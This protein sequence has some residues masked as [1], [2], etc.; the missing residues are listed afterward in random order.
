[1]K[2]FAAILGTL[3]VVLM[4]VALIACEG[5]GNSGG[6]GGDDPRFVAATVAGFSDWKVAPAYP[7][8]EEASL[9]SSKYTISG[10]KEGNN[11][12]LKVEYTALVA[13]VTAELFG[14]I[15]ETGI[16]V[17]EYDGFV[18]D[19][20]YSAPAP[21]QL[22]ASQRYGSD[23]NTWNGK[24][25]INFGRENIYGSDN[26][27]NTIEFVPDP[28]NWGEYDGIQ[29]W[30]GVTSSKDPSAIELVMQSINRYMFFVEVPSDPGDRVIYLD[31]VGFYKEGGENLILWTFD[32][33]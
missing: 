33:E 10:V 32:V 7:N 30:N 27:W 3:L 25:T 23:E 6:G 26:Q 31:N 28:N 13:G 22:F 17:S 19:I 18:F 5:N 12:A 8:S 2:K 11:G 9:D 29:S 24:A 15:N 1:M 4:A 14:D 20:Y 21:V 16:D